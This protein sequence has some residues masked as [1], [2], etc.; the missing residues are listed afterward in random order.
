MA[1][2]RMTGLASGL[3]TESLVGELSKAYQT[4]VDNAKKAQ[5]KA[6]WKK[7]AWA[8]LNTKLMNFYKGALSTFKS[9]GTYNTKAVTGNLTGMKVSANAKAVNGTHKIKVNS[10]AS[11]QMWTGYQIGGKGHTVTATS[12]EAATDGSKK[13]SELKNA[14]GYSI[15]NELNGS[16]FKVS[17]N[18]VD[19]EVNINIDSDTTVDDMISNINSQLDGT[20]LTASFEKGAL[21]FT[22]TSVGADG[23]PGYDISVV[24]GNE[25][26]AIALG[27][28]T[29]AATIKPLGEGNTKNTYTAKAFAYEEKKTPDATVTGST[30]LTDLGIAE[31]TVIKVNGTEINVDRNTTL[32]SLSTAMANTGIN[33]S[34]DATQGRFYLSAKN[35]GTENAF[36]VEADDATLSA[37]GLKFADGYKGKIDASDASVTYNGVEYTQATNA[38]EING[39][40]IEASAVGEE[41]TFTV[42]NDVDGI[43]DKVKS[44]VKEYNEL[45]TE[46]NKLYNA[47]STRGYEPLTSDEKEAMNDEDIKNWEDKIKGSLLRRDSTISSL[48]TNMR[49]ILNKAVDVTNP[50]GTTSKFALSSFGIVTSDYTEKGQLHIQGDPDDSSFMDLDNKLKSAIASNPDA[51][52][53]TLTSLGNEMYEHFMKAMKK[54]ETS[55]SMTFYN[56]ITMDKD[57]KKRKEDVTDLQDKLTAEE[58]KYYKQFSAME[59]AMSRLQSQQSYV[60]QL[61]GGM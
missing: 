13:I 56:D 42:D 23:S 6:E 61:F 52:T 40:T 58:D 35:T 31:N 57:I 12:Y 37:L 16:S 5:T 60:A 48:L 9:S 25:A 43:F 34:Y 39:L 41:Q 53:K 46:M 28:S 38:F 20:G 22:N 44:F 51:V 11:A 26:S 15:Q 36:T 45:I 30:R 21:K 54:T 49:T 29:E 32:S 59:T 3:D 8:S 1:G 7:E 47:D 50:D 2:V 24:A 19:T 33:A 17:A 18:G 27:L 55:S 10:T 14:Q 4:K